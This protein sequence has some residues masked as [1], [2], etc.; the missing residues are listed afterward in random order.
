MRSRPYNT[1]WPRQNA[2]IVTALVILA[3]GFCLVHVNHHQGAPDGM[4]PDPCAMTVPSLVLVLLAGH[5]VSG[6]LLLDSPRRVYAFSLALLDPP[7][8]PLLL[9]S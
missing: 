2:L 1:S 5:L 9:L 6:L 8:R 7:P 3:V 4:C